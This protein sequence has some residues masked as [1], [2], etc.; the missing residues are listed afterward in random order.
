L[1]FWILF[2]SFDEIKV[3]RLTK[4]SCPTLATNIGYKLG[5]RE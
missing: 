2:Q 5:A 1:V 3:A 4:C